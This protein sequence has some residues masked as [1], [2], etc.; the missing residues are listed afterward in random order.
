MRAE[1]QCASCGTLIP[2]QMADELHCPACGAVFDTSSPLNPFASPQAE[3]RSDEVSKEDPE[4]PRSRAQRKMR[5]PVLGCRVIVGV[6]LF[7][8]TIGSVLV[9]YQVAFVG[10][11]LIDAQLGLLGALAYPLG[12]I[13]SLVGLYGLHNAEKL[14]NP[15]WAWIGIIISGVVGIAFWV[16]LPFVVWAA[17]VLCSRDAREGFRSARRAPE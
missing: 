14:E 7:L 11:R 6:V 8:A 17:V 15:V 9:L 13:L 4:S 12:I 5:I 2:R 16:V 3:L 1:R 10:W